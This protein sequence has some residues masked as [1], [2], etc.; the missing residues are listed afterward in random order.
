MVQHQTKDKLNLK[1]LKVMSPLFAELLIHIL[2]L[3]VLKAF[4]IFAFANESFFY[5]TILVNDDVELQGRRVPI[6]TDT[7]GPDDCNGGKSF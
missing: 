3:Q 2:Q 4:F 5:M 1:I 6:P 7:V